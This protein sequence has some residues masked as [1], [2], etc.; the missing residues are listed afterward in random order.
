MDEILQSFRLNKSV[1]AI[2]SFDD[3]LGEREYWR[4]KTSLERLAALEFMRT[5]SYGYDPATA[6]LRRLLTV[7]PLS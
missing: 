3:D 7:R 1:L 5:V 4:S 6:R 2:G